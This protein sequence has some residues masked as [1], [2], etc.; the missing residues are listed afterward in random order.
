MFVHPTL[1]KH[2]SGCP[3]PTI[4][5]PPSPPP[6]GEE[7]AAEGSLFAS[8]LNS[9]KCWDKSKEVAIY[10]T[11]VPNLIM[12]EPLTLLQQESA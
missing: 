12:T 7:K 3:N 9:L 6:K 2:L 1:S 4:F 10:M 5:I 11:Y 8:V